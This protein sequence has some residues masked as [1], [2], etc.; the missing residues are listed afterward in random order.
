MS[1][2]EARP[3]PAQSPFAHDKGPSLHSSAP[4]A[5]PESTRQPSAAAGGAGGTLLAH[6][7]NPDTA[8]GGKL[9]KPGSHLAQNLSHWASGMA[10][11]PAAAGER[12]KESLSQPGSKTAEELSKPGMILA[13]SLSPAATKGAAPKP[14]AAEGQPAINWS[15]DSEH[16]ADERSAADYNI[17]SVYDSQRGV[18][19][20]TSNNIRVEV[21]DVQLNLPLDNPAAMNNLLEQWRAKKNAD[22]Q[23]AY[24]KTTGQ[25][26][27]DTKQGDTGSRY[28]DSEQHLV[29]AYAASART[30]GQIPPEFFLE[31]DPNG[32][33]AGNGPEVL[34]LGHAGEPLSTIAMGHDTD[35]NLGRYMNAGPLQGLHDLNPTDQTQMKRMGNAGLFNSG[36]SKLIAPRGPTIGDWR[37]GFQ[38]T[39]DQIARDAE[40][41]RIG[42]VLDS[43]PYF[44]NGNVNDNVLGSAF[45]NP[46]NPD[47]QTSY[48]PE[49]ASYGNGGALNPFN[50]YPQQYYW[51]GSNPATGDVIQNPAR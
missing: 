14:V 39:P 32:G 7:S 36:A 17:H 2:Y 10:S 51:D 28:Y 30:G 22:D 41:D 33:T 19:V 34:P 47:W 25:M 48:R 5:A 26:L 1:T 6:A 43:V 4:A 44:Y 38:L 3:R 24:G 18:Y 45:N 50:A 40:D 12:L 35:W 31:F 15:T 37:N 21:K 29:W 27:A 11:Q 49:Y 16:P 46:H 8:L 13:S 20:V 9:H 42:S 23:L